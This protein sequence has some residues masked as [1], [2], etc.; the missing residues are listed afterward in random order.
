MFFSFTYSSVDKKVILAVSIRTSSFSLF[1][2]HVHELQVILFRL[3]LDG[4][5]Y[6]PP[7]TLFSFR[8]MFFFSISSRPDDDYRRLIVYGCERKAERERE[9]KERTKHIQYS[10]SSTKR[11]KR[12]RRKRRRRKQCTSTTITDR[13]EVLLTR[14][15]GKRFSLSLCLSLLLFF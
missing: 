15:H 6:Y 4:S 14:T 10:C 7:T 2:F 8:L 3:L 13:V 9:K 1:F 5:C 12:K 11:K